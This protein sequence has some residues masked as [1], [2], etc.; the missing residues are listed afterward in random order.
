[1]QSSSTSCNIGVIVIV[2]VD[3]AVTAGAAAIGVGGVG[4]V[5][6]DAVDVVDVAA[7]PSIQR[8]SA[9]MSSTIVIAIVIAVAIDDVILILA[10][11]IVTAVV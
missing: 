8:S 5:T 7:S 3:D 9:P 6:D 10:T 1:M 11:N 4:A 2:V